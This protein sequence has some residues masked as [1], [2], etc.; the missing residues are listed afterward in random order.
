MSAM[1]QVERLGK[2]FRR[3]HADRPRTLKQAFLSGLRGRR[4]PELFWSLRNVSFEV[5]RGRMVGII[6]GNGAGKTTLLRLIGGIFRPD[7]GVVRI[8]GQTRGL[9]ELG[10]SFQP[11]LNGRENLI[12]A[13]IIDGLT[14]REVEARMD[15]ILDFAD[16]HHAIDYPI[17]TFSSGMQMRLAFAISTQGG[18]DILLIDECLTVGDMAFQNKCLDRLRQLKAEGSA[19]VLVSHDTHLLGQMCD[20]LLWL[21]RGELVCQGEPKVV[22]ERYVDE[23]TMETRRRTPNKNPEKTP[24]ARTLL[25]FNENRFGSQELEIRAV[26]LLDQ[27]E[28]PVTTIHSG[29]S[30][31]VEVEFHTAQTVDA[32]IFVVTISREDGFVCLDVNTASAGISLPPVRGAGRIRLW[33]ERL[34][35]TEGHYFVDVGGY[36]REWAYTYDYHWHVYPLSVQAS[37]KRKGILAPPTRWEIIPP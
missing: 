31:C 4:P 23:M 33:I 28:M 11:D 7:E 29:S 36:E 13:G 9:L 12:L 26:R 30:L 20:E 34:D 37:D 17:R 35:L 27:T 32:P 1:I 16:L 21:R 2:L 6:G 19:I 25:Q 10:S 22:L 3:Y 18:G 15:A 14:K 5:S 8:H 24:G